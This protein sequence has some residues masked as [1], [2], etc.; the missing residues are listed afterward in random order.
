MT[1]L[2][3]DTM[4][5]NKE[6]FIFKKLQGAYNYKKWT[7]NMTFALQDAKLWDH[8]IATTRRPPGLEKTEKDN[9]DRKKC[10]Y[11]RQKNIRDFDLNIQRTSAKISKM[12]T[13]TIKKKFLVF[14]NSTK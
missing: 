7:Q 6:G 4:A 12:C 11:Q 13:Y 8:I 3:D 10:I 2:Y 14:K 9:K 5:I 1:A